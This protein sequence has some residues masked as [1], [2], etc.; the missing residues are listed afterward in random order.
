MIQSFA[1]S[2]KEEGRFIKLHGIGQR[3]SLGNLR[4]AIY[5]IDLFGKLSCISL[6][7]QSCQVKRKQNVFNLMLIEVL[8]IS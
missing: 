5:Q 3:F 4:M 7:R 1:T 6:F 2:K 8:F